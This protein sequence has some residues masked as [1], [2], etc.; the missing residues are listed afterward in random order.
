V[1]VSRAYTYGVDLETNEEGIKILEY[2]MCIWVRISG[3]IKKVK[4]RNEKKEP[5]LSGCDMM[6]E[7]PWRE[8][9]KRKEKGA[10]LKHGW[11]R[12]GRKIK[13]KLG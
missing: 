13:K 10:V 12:N 4:V 9:R 11:K 8:K 2:D 7:S 6:S 3:S 1:S 5:K